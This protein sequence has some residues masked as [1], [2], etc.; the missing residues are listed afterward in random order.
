M[1]VPSRWKDASTIYT[2]LQ[3]TQIHSEPGY[4][5]DCRENTHTSYNDKILQCVEKWPQRPHARN[6]LLFIFIEMQLYI[7]NSVYLV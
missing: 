6:I 2:D 5:N 1:V 7:I 3:N 4:G